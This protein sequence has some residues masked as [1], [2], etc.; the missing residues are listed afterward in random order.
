MLPESSSKS[1]NPFVRSGS[2]EERSA[3]YATIPNGIDILVTHGPPY[4]ILDRE[5]GSNHR[6]GC[7]V[8]LEAVKRVRPRLHVFGHVHA[9]YGTGQGKFTA[10]VNAALLGWAGDLE[11]PP[12]VLD[13]NSR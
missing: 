6:Q 12:I 3:L 10:Y 5:P 8:L 4:G 9:G 2:I 1:W 11:N 13:I 7:P